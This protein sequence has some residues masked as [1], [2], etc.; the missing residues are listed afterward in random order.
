M[1]KINS[2]I[3]GNALIVALSVAA[4]SCGTK[5]AVIGGASSTEINVADGNAESMKMDYLRKVYDNEVYTRSISSKMKFTINAGGKDISV[6]GSLKMKK[7]DVIRIQLTPL[8][9]MEAGRLEFTKDYVLI[10][11]RINKEYV[12]A[13]YGEVDFLR[14]N[15]L[16]FYALQA[17]F[18]NQ[19]FVP[20][21][22]K[23]TDSQLRNFTVDLTKAATAVPVTLKRDNMTY[24]WQTDNNSGQIRQVDV[25]YSSN[26]A[27]TTSVKC[28]YGGFKP[29]GTKRFPTDMTLMMQSTMLKGGKGASVNISMGTLDTSDDWESRTTVS[30]KYKKVDTQDVMKRLLSL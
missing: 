5:K 26:A 23:I 9:L 19:L 7:D 29:L 27:G 3:L 12:K 6:S 2:R 21:S 11:D 20:G 14:R 17:L 15:G 4:V 8:G 25:T 22:E 24:V 10:I 16:D 13:G 28:V 18:W 30:G 1:W